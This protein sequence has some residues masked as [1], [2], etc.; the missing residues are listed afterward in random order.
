[1]QF[2]RFINK[3][4]DRKYF[5]H[6]Q[7]EKWLKSISKYKI[8]PLNEFAK[9]HNDN[10]VVIGL[11]HDS[12]RNFSSTVSLLDVEYNNFVRSSLYVL[13]TADY[14]KDRKFTYTLTQLQDKGFEI[15]LHQDCMS[16]L[17]P[18]GI[19]HKALKRLRDSGLNIIGTSAHGDKEHKNITFW[20]YFDKSDFGLEYE[21]YSLNHTKYFSDCTFIDGHRWHPGL[22]D[23]DSLK[24]GERVLVTLHPEHWRP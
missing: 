16:S 19:M 22:F 2:V 3:I 11:R 17:C 13:H 18:K 1:M 9:Y 7:Y 4:R 12:D 24:P 23:W 8:L 6:A 10:E 15:G 21:S 14:Y 20:D 5:T